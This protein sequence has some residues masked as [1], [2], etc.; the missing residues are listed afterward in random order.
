MNHTHSK[1]VEGWVRNAAPSK[2]SS[3]EITRAK[4]ERHNCREGLEY[5]LRLRQGSMRMSKDLGLNKHNS[6]HDKRIKAKLFAI[7]GRL[8][9]IM[10]NG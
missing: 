1:A 9:R 5:Q 7:R 2:P 8:L 4:I 3:V 6:K 10:N